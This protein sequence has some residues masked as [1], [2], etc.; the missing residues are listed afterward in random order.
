MVQVT[1]PQAGPSH[2]THD[3]VGED[4]PRAPPQG[5]GRNMAKK[6]ERDFDEES[7]D[8]PRRRK[9]YASPPFTCPSLL[10]SEIFY[11]EP[12]A[13]A[14]DYC[15]ESDIFSIPRTDPSSLLLGS[16]VKSSG[17]G[18]CVVCGAISSI[19][20][21]YFQILS[22]LAAGMPY[23]RDPLYNIAQYYHL[24]FVM[25]VLISISTYMYSS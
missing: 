1:A 14:H 4:E 13:A 5:I 21:S 24:I 9:V 11:R 3:S 2:I 18:Y 22:A 7:E 19:F 23:Y 17:Y 10:T 6:R 20:E 8:D 12:R 16:A 25:Q 15:Q